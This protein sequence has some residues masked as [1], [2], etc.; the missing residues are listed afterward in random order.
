MFLG[1]WVSWSGSAAIGLFKAISYLKG[2][3]DG[4]FNKVEPGS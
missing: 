3:I 2:G 4:A 1:V